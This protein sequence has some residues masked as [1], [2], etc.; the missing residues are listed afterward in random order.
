MEPVE[1]L[2]E[3]GSEVSKPSWKKALG[4]ASFMELRQGIM[5]FHEGFTECHEGSLE[6]REGLME[7]H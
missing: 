5:E 6:F 2:M 4:S 7:S 3:R 1:G